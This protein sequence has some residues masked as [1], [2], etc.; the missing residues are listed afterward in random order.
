MLSLLLRFELRYHLRQISFLVAAILFLGLGFLMS[1]GNFGGNEIHTNGPYVT[2]YA[3]GFLSLFTLFVSI[4]FCV[5]VVLRDAAAKMDE[6]V[7]TTSIR[8]FSYFG[9]RFLGLLLAVFAMMVLAVSGLCLG[10]LLSG[11]EQ[12]GP[13]RVVYFLQ[14][15][16]VFGLPNA[17][18][19]SSVV[20][21]VA[22]L[23]RSA[24][25]VYVAGV[26]VFIL[27]FLGSILGQSP[28]MASSALKPHDNSS[29]PYLLDPFGLS[30]FFGEARSW[31]VAQRNSRLLP[32]AG[33]FLV[34]RLLWTGLSVLLLFISH[35]YF[36]FRLPAGHSQRKEKAAK[37]DFKTIPYQP[38]PVRATGGAYNRSVFT[39]QLKL[40]LGSVFRHIPFLV[41][42][43]LWL[44]LYAVDLKESLRGP[45]GIRYYATTG[46]IVEQFL[47]VRPALLLL[48]FYAAELV[49]RERAA[50][51]QG[52]IFSTPVPEA[53]LWSAK[54]TA[55]A[56]L[57]GI[58]VTANICIGVGFQL[59]TGTMPVDILA[60]FS[61]FYYSGWPLVLFAVLIIFIQTIVPNK[62]LGML[63][64]LTVTG[65]FVFGRAWGIESYLLRYA[66]LPGLKHSAMNGF[67]HYRQAVNGYLLYWTFL[68]LAL[69]LVAAGMGQGSPYVGWW[70]RVR[71]MGLQWGRSGKLLLAASLAAFI[72]TGAFIQAGTKDRTAQQATAWQVAYEKKY[73]PHRQLP[74]PVITAVKTDVDLYPD[75]GRYTVK[76]TYRLRNESGAPIRKLWLGAD[77]G[78]TT[79]AFSLPGAR[80]ES[81]DPVFRQYAYLLDKPLLPEAEMNLEFSM[82]VLRSGFTHFN[83]EH[84]VVSNGS[85][86][87]LEKYVPFLGYNDRYETEDALVRKAN[88]LAPLVAGT[89]TDT[90]YHLIDFETTVSTAADQQV[91]TV[92]RLQRQ[93]KTGDRSYFHYKT[94]RPIAFMFALS[95]ARYVVRKEN[96]KGIEFCIYHHPGHTANVPAMMQ[97]MKD[98]VDYGNAHFSA[99]PLRYLGLAEIPQYPGAATAYPG[100]V[101]SAE[102]I[103]FMTD[104]SDS[105]RFNSIYATTAHE[106]AHQWWANALVP[107]S[108]PG[109][110]VLTES[111]AKYTEA[112]VVE[113]RFGKMYLRQ[114]LQKDNG[115]YF[116]MRN[117]SGE[118]E[119]PLAQTSG[120]PYVYYQKGGM[121]LY[122]IKEELGEER[123]SRALQ[124]LICRHGYPH[125]RAA[126]ADL[127]GE[128][129]REATPAEARHIAG[130]FQKVIVYDNRLQLL[131]CVPTTDGRFRLRL[132]VKMVKTD[133]TG[134]RPR[135]MVPDDVI[136]VAAFDREEAA[137]DRH[138]QPVYLHRQL[139]TREGTE[140]LIELDQK[141]RMLV[142]DP[143][144]CLPDSNPEN[145]IVRVP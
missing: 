50:N 9:V 130:H 120:Q 102:R 73:G 125:A 101:F 14:P 137:W 42:M 86:I 90:G 67:G 19:G 46:F 133:E 98:A 87:E 128:L 41:L 77:P 51:M 13:F 43:A 122:A 18:F 64:S 143:Y 12:Q 93:W 35:R 85:Y 82:E 80:L 136:A 104:F 114:Y 89:A 7:F 29:L 44:F 17:L 79:V 62:Y 15:L 96:Y 71:S 23:T 139:F 27:Y 95:S 99:Y 103:N 33:M 26:L 108:A 60:Y 72:I 69:A 118:R 131:S 61:L 37:K 63:L 127:V 4:L 126:V 49:G 138:T 6:I 3:A 78:V 34:N 54:C 141:P 74:Q 91:V 31:S 81:A 52:L 145:N 142:L 94:G 22:M 57:A 32:L 59:F 70:Q 140:L 10:A 11:P 119:L 28:I 45:Y 66:A 68:A 109:R 105:N 117:E 124:R 56:M 115:I 8:R 25:A 76:G 112:M 58:L 21:S 111:L 65:V 107:L 20:F 106:V 38:S 88:G 116:A 135:A 36:R 83:S 1:Q 144:S 100:V 5:N 2:S 55:L 123:M 47:Q 132:S 129:S 75:A 39:S 134:T 48:V 110:P 97:A 121:L 16:L 92:G 113:K 40:E 30:A 84:S 53:V 24:R